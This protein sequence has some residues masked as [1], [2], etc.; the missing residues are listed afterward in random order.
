ML[1]KIEQRSQFHQP[2]STQRKDTFVHGRKG[3]F[4]FTNISADITIHNISWNY[5]A[6]VPKE[7]LKYSLQQLLV[8][9]F[10]EIDSTAFV[11]LDG[12]QR[13][14]GKRMHILIR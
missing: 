13:T 9:S 1:I 6:I 5:Y 12:F 8:N 14:L 4:C 3:T 10:G 11:S 2:N 7:L